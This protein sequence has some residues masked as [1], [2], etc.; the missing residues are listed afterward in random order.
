MSA[1]STTPAT[2]THGLASLIG[3]GQSGRSLAQQQEAGHREHRAQHVAEVGG[4]QDRKRRGDEQDHQ[5][6]HHHVHSERAARFAEPV[7]LVEFP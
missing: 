3:R 1:T 5:R 6:V 2:K 7:E 4:E